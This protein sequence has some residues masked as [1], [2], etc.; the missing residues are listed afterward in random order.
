M[1]IQIIDIV[2]TKQNEIIIVGK[3]REGHIN[4]ITRTSHSPCFYIEV[5]EDFKMMDK[6]KQFSSVHVQISV[7]IPAEAL[8]KL[9]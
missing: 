6:W 3:D 9:W 8:V 5:D 2:Q 7:V 4:K 1:E